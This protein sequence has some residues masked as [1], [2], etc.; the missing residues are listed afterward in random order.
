[1]VE[2][3][4]FLR[5]MFPNGIQMLDTRNISGDSMKTIYYYDGICVN[6]CSHYNYIEIFGL[7]EEEFEIVNSVINGYY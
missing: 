1:M 4:V 3:I 2:L 5:N 6:Y 7:S